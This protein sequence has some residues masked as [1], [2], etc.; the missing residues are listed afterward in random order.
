MRAD[1]LL[2]GKSHGL[3]T[4]PHVFRRLSAP[5]DDGSKGRE[6]SMSAKQKIGNYT[7]LRTLGVGSFG[8]VKRK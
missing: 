5:K 7:V 3:A 6:K 2:E 4:L 8:K 1:I